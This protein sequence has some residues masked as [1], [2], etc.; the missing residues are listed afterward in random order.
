MLEKIES[1]QNKQVKEWKK[2]LSRKGRKKQ[3]KYIIE[4]VHL[5]EE[6]RRYGA[7]IDTLLIREDKVDDYK[8]LVTD[9]TLLISKE[10]AHTL[11]DAITDQ[12]ILAIVDIR[13]KKDAVELDKPIL[14][15][16]EVQDP[17]NIGTLI[18]SADAAGFGAVILGKGSA[19]LYNPKTIRSTQGSH[20]HLSVIQD[21]LEEWVERL[22]MAG[23]P[24]YGTALDE[25][26]VSHRTVSPQD[27]F[28]L[29]VGNEGSGVRPNLLSQ[30]T[31]NLYIPIKGKA[32]SLNVA[33][34]GSILMFALYP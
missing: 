20:F 30:T 28:G 15:V 31:K 29:I 11:T 6:A 7:S 1:T 19:D 16:D 18:R 5:V 2:L 14:L 17:G 21:E 8:E 22:K 4:G 25:R 9:S 10:V 24:V 32:E 23:H 33:V 13:E 12:G 27:S 26:A 34:A 3:K